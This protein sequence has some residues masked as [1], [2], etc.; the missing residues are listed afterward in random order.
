MNKAKLKEKLLHMQEQLI[1]EFKEKVELSHS[2]VDLDEDGTIDPE[3]FSHQYEAGETEELFK[4]QLSRAKGNLEELKHLNFDPKII[5]EPGAVVQTD[6][7][8]FILGFSSVPFEMDG[9]QYM[10]ISRTAPIYACL[11][12]RKPGHSFTFCGITYRI[13]SIH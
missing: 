12:G 4:L 5:V 7:R 11:Q 8:Y 6:Q 13:N 3:D 2:M 1:L 10:G 9:E